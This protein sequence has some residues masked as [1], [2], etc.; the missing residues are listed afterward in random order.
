MRLKNKTALITGGSSGIGKEVCIAYAA[1][2]ANVIVNYYEDNDKDANDVV[3]R[4]K[5]KGGNATSF[6]CDVGYEKEINEML[7]TVIKDWGGVDILVNNAGIYPRKKWYEITSE[8]WDRVHSV[9]LKACFLTS[10]GVFPYMKNKGYGKIINVSSVTFWSGQKGFLHYVSSKGGV[11]G[12]TRALAREVG[13]HGISVNA[14]TPGAVQTEKELK[15]LRDLKKRKE[16]DE[17][18]RK[19]QSF[20]RRQI[21]KDMV[22]TFVF[23]AS[24]E[25]DFITG[26][27]LNVDG[28]WM[29][30]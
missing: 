13:E 3:K 9:N 16:N 19:S 14:I 21:P 5:E 17:F 6:C 2:G 11:I 28:G 30:H 29:M 15:D 7:V 4:I 10:K 26:Q 25:S 24:E 8:E 18:L 22:G 1:E 20:D 27:T 23:L 12:L